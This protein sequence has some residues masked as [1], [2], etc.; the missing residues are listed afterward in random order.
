MRITLPLVAGAIIALV[1][2]WPEVGERRKEFK[3]GVSA[4]SVNE[5]GGQQ[6]VK[7]RF[8][9]TDRDSR[10][11]TVTAD[12]AVQSKDNP[13]EVEL[14]FPKADVTL[15]DGA[16]LAVSAASGRFDRK[17]EILALKGGVE[18]FH[19]KGYELHTRAARVDL[20]K[21]Q[22]SG[23]EPVRGQ[24][25]IGTLQGRGFR[26]L[27]KGRRLLITGKSRLVLYPAAGKGAP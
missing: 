27:D 9:G 17:G 22:A 7:P 4:I 16:W 18:L 5:K 23:D 11:F 8:T 10:P 6:V 3:V 19:D 15:H 14:A 2:A 12:S 25:P 26:V 1:I 21:G 24:G 20:G 13:T